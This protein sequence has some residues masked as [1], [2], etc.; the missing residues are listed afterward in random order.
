MPAYDE[1]LQ[2]AMVNSK[3][4]FHPNVIIAEEFVPF[5]D[6]TEPLVIN[7][8]VYR[9]Y[10]YINVPFHEFGST[11]PFIQ[12]AYSEETSSKLTRNGVRYMWS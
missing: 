2:E 6:I 5:Y 3:L 8:D 12:Q 10:S 11:L 7:G 9:T 4:T 1:F